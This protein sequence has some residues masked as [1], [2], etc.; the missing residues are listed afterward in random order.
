M[1]QPVQPSAFGKA[2]AA[3]PPRAILCTPQQGTWVQPVCCAAQPSA[4]FQSCLLCNPWKDE[5]AMQ[6]PHL[7]FKASGTSPA[8]S[9]LPS[10]WPGT[11]G[12]VEPPTVQ[13]SCLSCLARQALAVSR[14]ACRANTRNEV[15]VLCTEAV[16]P[17]QHQKRQQPCILEPACVV[18]HART[19]WMLCQARRESKADQH[20]TIIM[21]VC[22]WAQRSVPVTR[23]CRRLCA[24]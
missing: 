1:R 3:L 11:G 24:L 2:A 10:R 22:G 14:P 9:H 8:T 23:R 16:L 18:F 6:A 19:E 20:A 13:A 15:L 5:A 21:A 17:A 12:P 4:R 7:S